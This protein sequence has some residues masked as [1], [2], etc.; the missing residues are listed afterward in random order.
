MMPCFRMLLLRRLRRISIVDCVAFEGGGWGNWGPC[1]DF[2]GV[3]GGMLIFFFYFSSDIIDSPIYSLVGYFVSLYGIP[4]MG[5]MRVK[6]MD[7]YLK[8]SVELLYQ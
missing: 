4:W 1:W 2:S 7:L 3:W 6:M 8:A 5:K